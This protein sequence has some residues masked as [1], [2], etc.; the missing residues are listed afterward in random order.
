MIGI[1][2]PPTVIEAPS[3]LP[4]RLSSNAGAPCALQSKLPQCTNFGTAALAKMPWYAIAG[5]PS[6]PVMSEA[7]EPH[8]PHTSNNTGLSCELQFAVAQWIV[9]NAVWPG[10]GPCPLE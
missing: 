7:Y 3:G 6:A 8:C 5:N 10:L 9:D 2:S 1:P 4:P